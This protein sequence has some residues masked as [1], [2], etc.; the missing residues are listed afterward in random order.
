[1]WSVHDLFFLRGSAHKRPEDFHF[2]C[3]YRKKDKSLLGISF[4]LFD[5]KMLASQ[6]QL[7]LISAFKYLLKLDDWCICLCVRGKEGV[8][9]TLIITRLADE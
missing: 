8:L 9:E 2:I 3:F 6:L 4:L 5:C 7:N 1:M